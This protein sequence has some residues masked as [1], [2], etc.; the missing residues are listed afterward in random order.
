MA[1]DL[2]IEKSSIACLNAR[3]CNVTVVPYGATADEIMA[4]KPDGV[5]VSNGPSSPEYVPE[6]VE[7]VKNLVGKTPVFAIGLGNL[8]LASAYGAIVYKMKNEHRGGNHP[9]RNL[10]TGKIE[11]VSQ[12]HGYAINADSVSATAL[13]VSHVNVL[14]GSVEGVEC[15]KDVAFGVQYHPES[16]AGHKDN[17]YLID[18]FVK[19]MEDNRNA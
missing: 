2:G 14:D 16:S 18:K 3:G 11:I 6:I 9:V 17:S 8:V 13:T 1:I 5:F 15:A 19:N 12:N 4:L 7:T 10:S